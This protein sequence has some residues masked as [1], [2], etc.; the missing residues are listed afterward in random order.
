MKKIC[1]LLPLLIAAFTMNAQRFDW[2]TGYT[3]DSENKR[4][5]GGVTD[6]TGNLY[7]LGYCNFSSKWDGDEYVIPSINKTAKSEDPPSVVIAKINTEGE[8]VWKKVIFGNNG[9]GGYPNCIRK[10]GDSAFACMVGFCP[11]TSQHYTYFLDTLIIGDSEYPINPINFGTAMWTAY[12]VF[13]FDGNLIEQHYLNITYTD[14]DGNDIVYYAGPQ[15]IPYRYGNYYEFATFDI[16]KEG[17]I[18]ICRRALDC[19][20]P[21][22]SVENGVIQGLKFWVDRRLAGI[23]SIQCRPPLETPQMVKFSPHFDTLLACRYVMQRS[24]SIETEYYNYGSYFGSKTKVD[25]NGNVYFMHFMLPGR[26]NSN[27]III[28]SLAGISFSHTE[29]NTWISFLVK[30]DSQLNARWAIAFGDSVINNTLQ[31]RIIFNDYDFDTDS[32]LLLIFAQTGRS[33][34]RDTVNLY[35]VMTYQGTP[36]K[37]KSNTFFCAF[38]NND[39]NPTLHSYGVV[40]ELFIDGP[41]L[42]GKCKNNRVFM[43]N[44][45]GGGIKFPTQTINL[46]NIY[47]AGV[48]LTVFDYSGRVIDGIDYGIE[49]QNANNC[50]GPIVL[51]DSVLY[52]CNNFCAS[53]TF[54]SIHYP[55]FDRANV[56]ARYVDTAFMHPYVRPTHGINTVTAEPELTLAPNPTTGALTVSCEAAIEA[57]ELYDM[58]GRCVLSRECSGTLAV[59][60]LKAL[61][62]GTYVLVAHTAK[63]SATR[64]VEKR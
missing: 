44:Q 48:A 40:P 30:Y 28:D 51:H 7:I 49:T 17:N 55:V 42:S 41:Y 50:L 15:Q 34:Y 18:Y 58:Q 14:A 23:Y 38:D 43:Q 31:S 47:K 29:K 36:L 19:F 3:V 45:Y 20:G 64:T 21:T 4:I 60:D 61:P 24:D 5:V 37:I 26:H 62:A 2:A 8:M 16:D 12:L 10:I 39:T 1:L 22:I 27:T 11:P 63:G 54:G 52:L 9:T 57:V 56:I 59:L 32:N 25:S 13:D 33:T 6:S 46:S 53:P 35:S